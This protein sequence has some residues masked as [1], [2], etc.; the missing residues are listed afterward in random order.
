MVGTTIMHAQYILTTFTPGEAERI[1]GLSTTM[2][3]DWRRREFLP[4][5]EGQARFDVF[6][7]AKMWTL[8]LLSDRGIG[9]QTAKDVAPWCAT[10]IVWNAL[11][12][13][14]SYEGDH[15]R[16]FDWYPPEMRPQTVPD[17]DLL[18]ML[19]EI[20][21]KDPKIKAPS[22][23]SWEPKAQWLAKQIMSRQGL[24]RIIPAPYFIWWADGTHVF[25][26]SLRDAFGGFS[27]D[28]RYAGPVVILDLIALASTLG[29][30]AG[31]PL[32]HVEFPA[33]PATGE[34]LS[35]LKYGNPVP[36]DTHSAEDADERLRGQ[37][38]IDQ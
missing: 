31:R 16:T 21:A 24:P 22:D 29:E 18:K 10:G 19:E 1:T 27:S 38:A 30:R 32:V 11:R 20:A 2:Q 37:R 26:N 8:K 13:S 14:D 5:A 3:R 25:H 35:P 6:G 12:W 33:D 36:L 23:F 15:L 7:L 9:P 34:L 28:P 4:I 17:P